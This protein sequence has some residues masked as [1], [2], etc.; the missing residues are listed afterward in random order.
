MKLGFNSVTQVKQV[1]LTVKSQTETYFRYARIADRSR[2]T[3][4]TVRR[5]WKIPLTRFSLLFW[6][7]YF[8]LFKFLG[9][10]LLSS[11]FIAKSISWSPKRPQKQRTKFVAWW[12][13][14]GYQQ[15]YRNTAHLSVCLFACKS[16]TIHMRH[17]C[18][19]IHMKNNTTCSLFQPLR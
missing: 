14:C 12:R 5:H 15:K 17:E 3:G 10:I 13:Y 4:E 18:R 8:T 9:R 11:K 16:R 7:W 19:L 1:G 2:L 6:S